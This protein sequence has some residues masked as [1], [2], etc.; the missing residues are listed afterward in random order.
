MNTNWK[1]LNGFV[2]R[3]LETAE[4]PRREL[5]TSACDMTRMKKKE[6][7]PSR[8]YHTIRNRSF[9]Q[10]SLLDSTLV[11]TMKKKYVRDSCYRS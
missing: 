8:L 6:D 4:W 1:L 2:G 5:E 11:V 7:Q 9:H 10:A 3:E